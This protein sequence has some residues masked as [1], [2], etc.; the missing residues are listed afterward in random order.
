MDNIGTYGFVYHNA[1]GTQKEFSGPLFRVPLCQWF[2]TG[3]VFAGAGSAR[4]NTVASAGGSETPEW[5]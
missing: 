3:S 2:V 1:A 5:E 4:Y